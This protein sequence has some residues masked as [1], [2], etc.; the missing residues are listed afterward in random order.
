M[1]TPA[2]RFLVSALAALALTTVP[3]AVAGK[4]GTSGTSGCTRNAP[5]VSVDNNWGWSQWGSWGMPGQELEYFVTVMNYDV[6]CSASSFVVEVAAPSGFSVSLAT[7]TVSIKSSSSGYLR[8]YVTS[9]SPIADGDYP[10]AVTVRRAGTSEA[11]GS[12]QSNYKVYSTDTTAPT[13]FWQNPADGATISGRSYSVTVSSS[14][15]HAVK[16]IDLYV[17]GVLKSATAC[18]NVTYICQ[19]SYNWSL[20]R[21]ARGAHTVTFR[22]TDWMDNV[23][24]MTL[25]VTVS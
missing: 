11:A 21:T 6:G 2:A 14:D 15:D 7:N 18:D 9:P 4:P 20:R 1:R 3:V 19:L 22:S 10:L 24:S 17:D 5:A 8:A 12:A 25:N 13:L 23:G 16:K